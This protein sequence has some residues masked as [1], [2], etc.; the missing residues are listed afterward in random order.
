VSESS[1]VNG[2]SLMERPIRGDE[3]TLTRCRSILC[4][5]TGAR[6]IGPL[7]RFAAARGEILSVLLYNADAAELPLAVV[8]E[9]STVQADSDFQCGV[10]VRHRDPAKLRRVYAELVTEAGDDPDLPVVSETSE[11]F[12]S[13]LRISVVPTS[14]TPTKASN[15]FRP[16]DIA[17]LAMRRGLP[18][19]RSRVDSS[20]LDQRQ[21]KPLRSTRRRVGR[22]EASPAKTS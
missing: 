16:Y 22:I 8:R 13:K 6:T 10:S 12:I 5:E 2:Y 7:R 14:A 4:C 3:D 11:N 17:F 1:T 18:D 19:G 9:L 20:G 21:A 15:S